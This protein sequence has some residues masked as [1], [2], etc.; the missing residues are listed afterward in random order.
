MTSSPGSRPHPCHTAPRAPEGSAL[1][2]GLLHVE[3]A[4]TCV[5]TLIPGKDVFEE[6]E[7]GHRTLS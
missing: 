7:L 5:P 4:F 1:S 2:D 3:C 6:E